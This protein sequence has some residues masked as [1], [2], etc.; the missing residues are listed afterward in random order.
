MKYAIYGAGAIGSVLA[1]RLMK[2][3]EEVALIARGAHLEAI[4]KRGLRVKSGPFGDM[5]V[6][7]EASEDPADIGPVDAVLITVKAH[8]LA[9]I[10]PKIKLLTGPDTCIVPFQ[11]GV[12]WWYFHGLGGKWEGER[13]EAVD[14]AG[15]IS[16][17][18][19]ARRV[20]AGIAYCS[21][22]IAEPGVVVHPES[23]RFPLG[24]PSGERTDRIQALARSFT[25]AGLKAAIR[26]E[27]R[28]EIWVKLLGNVPFNP[29]SALTRATLGEL[30]RF[31][32]TCDLV[33]AIMGEVRAV[34]AAYGIEIGIGSERRIEGAR[35]VDAHKTSMLQDL[36]AGRRP[37]L[38]PIVGA[39]IEL[40]EKVDVDVPNIRT[41]YALTKLLMDPAARSPASS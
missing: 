27:I 38:E 11:N 6:R 8:G 16:R 4:Q 29:I 2:A 30:L 13:V 17:N 22:H 10:A 20:V 3:G 24:E 25:K 28:H 40:A 41:V 15:V 36:E 33:R 21:A 5:L 23:N 34:A 37:E 7:P 35:K 26:T 31:D 1:A 39:V 9:A 12:P 32:P 19:D 18:I 14:P